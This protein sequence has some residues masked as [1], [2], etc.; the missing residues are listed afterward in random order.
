M[1]SVLVQAL[2]YTQISEEGMRMEAVARGSCPSCG[3]PQVYLM[4]RNGRK[5]L[6]IECECGDTNTFDLET[7]SEALGSGDPLVRMLENFQPVG[8]P[9]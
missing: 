4:W 3:T 2:A 9:S 5:T 6:V 7:L 8:K 1:A